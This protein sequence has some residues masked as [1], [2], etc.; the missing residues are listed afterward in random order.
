MQI[1]SNLASEDDDFEADADNIRASIFEQYS[2]DRADIMKAMGHSNADSPPPPPPIAH[3]TGDPYMIAHYFTIT[4]LAAPV[5]SA[6]EPVVSSK[7]AGN[8]GFFS[9]KLKKFVASKLRFYCLSML[10]TTRISYY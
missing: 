10:Y 2:R 9:T 6:P 8:R 3:G 7:A 1:L 4:V 5:V